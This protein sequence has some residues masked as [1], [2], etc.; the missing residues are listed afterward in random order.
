MEPNIEFV[1]GGFSYNERF[2]CGF[3]H[4]LD[5]LIAVLSWGRLY[6]NYMLWATLWYVKK[7]SRDCDNKEA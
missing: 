3:Y 7:H 6:S 4:I 1:D 5:G 2:V